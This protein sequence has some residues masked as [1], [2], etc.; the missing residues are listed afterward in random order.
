MR[1]PVRLQT[2]IAMRSSLLRELL[3]LFGIGMTVLLGVLA[4]AAADA[5]MA[6]CNEPSCSVALHVPPHA[7]HPASL[8]TPDELARADRRRT[9]LSDQEYFS[10]SGIGALVCSVDGRRRTATAFLVGAF[11]IVVT[12]A[13]PF[14]ERGLWAKPEDCVYTTT[15]SFGQVRE[16]LPVA[17]IETQW[18]TEPDSFGDVTKD[19]AVIR[20]AT[21]SQYAQRT[22]PLAKFAERPAN[23]VM[24]GF[25]ADVDSM[26]AK[27]KAR[28]HVYERQAT[29]QISTPGGF[30]HDLD[31]SG[32]AHGAPIIDEHSGVIIGVHTQG[33]T[34]TGLAS[35]TM[36]AMNEWLETTLR[37][38]IQLEQN[39]G[40]VTSA[41]P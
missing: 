40:R 17:Y 24:V 36:I 41:A 28:G 18:Q 33:R 39:A 13:H 12:V 4:G 11:D 16:R 5:A 10:F 37:R 35:N 27:L 3:G 34:R 32:I 22:M 31:A 19:F 25:N 21:P 7:A 14:V 29:L 1:T 9:E 6:H 20:L 23:V 8:R 30:A 26:T 38:E 2:R 15:D